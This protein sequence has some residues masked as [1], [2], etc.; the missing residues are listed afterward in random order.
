M[1]S[2]EDRNY[3]MRRADEER[4]RARNLEQ[5]RSEGSTGGGLPGCGCLF[6]LFGIVALV[7]MCCLGVQ[8]SGTIADQC[9][10][11]GVSV[12]AARVV[13]DARERLRR[14]GV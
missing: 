12:C 14:V 2:P 3:P 4:E 9:S 6:W 7:V 11:E 13:D 8:Y 10:E 5:W 1:V